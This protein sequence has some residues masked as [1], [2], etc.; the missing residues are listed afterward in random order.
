MWQRTRCFGVR[1]FRKK[2]LVPLPRSLGQ[3]LPVFVGFRGG[4]KVAGK[5]IG[6]GGQGTADCVATGSEPLARLPYG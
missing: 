1:D 3:A 4:V 5:N 2:H 6:M